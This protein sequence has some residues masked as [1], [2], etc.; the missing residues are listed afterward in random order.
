[1]L[2]EK[3]KESLKRRHD[4]AIVLKTKCNK[5]IAR[6]IMRDLD[7]QGFD[8]VLAECSGKQVRLTKE[9]ESDTIILEEPS[10]ARVIFVAY[11]DERA[12]LREAENLRFRKFKR[13]DDQTAYDKDKREKID[14]LDA[15]II[16]HEEKDFFKVA[17]KEKYEG[18]DF[19]TILTDGEI[20]LCVYKLVSSLQLT[21]STS[22]SYK[23][24]PVN[25]YPPLPNE[26]LI[27][28]LL[29]HGYITE[30]VPLHSRSRSKENYKPLFESV[31]KQYK[32]PVEDL[33]SYYG[34]SVAIYFEWCNFM[35]RWLLVPSIISIILWL[36]EFFNA[37]ARDNTL[38]NYMF[39]VGITIWSPMLVRFW[40]RRCSEIDIEWDNYNL[41]TSA[42]SFRQEFKGDIRINPVTDLEEDHY[43]SSQRLLRYIES[44]IIST[45]FMTLAFIV[46]ISS[47]N[48]MGYSDKDDLLAWEFFAQMARQGGIFEKGTLMANI[49]SLFMSITMITIGVFYESA[50][51]YA[52]VRENHKTKEAHINSVNIKKF[53]FNFLFYFGHL[54]YVA[55]QRRDIDGLKKELI[56]LALVDEARRIFSESA[57]PTFMKYGLHFD[58]KFGSA[59]EEELNELTLPEYTYFEDYLELVIQFGYVSMFAVAFPLGA[60]ITYVFLFFERRSDAYKIEKLCRRPL[61]LNTSDIGIWDEV[62]KLISFTSVFTNLFLF[63]FH[64]TADGVVSQGC[65]SSSYFIGIEHLL[66]IAIFILHAI[67]S[68]K[69]KWVSIFL[70]RVDHKE[71]KKLILTSALNKFKGAFAKIRGIK[72]LT[73]K[74]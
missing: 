39:A 65:E 44:F 20:N 55:F 6:A 48:M 71:K 10:N 21:K 67:I 8:T 73:K 37:D 12:I 52:T 59:I 69:P 30:M 7:E 53:T 43:P 17:E 72:F 25:V 15:R 5:E 62:M 13:P 36:G 64:K 58:K 40:R 14:Y 51:K 41:S 22:N 9:T 3:Y 1:M 70:Q 28:Y 31:M 57:L 26:A 34:E 27:F 60:F 74:D 63:S 42:V 4:L 16:K 19:N 18:G 45:P 49:P 11:D 38:F 50:A 23:A 35:A 54:F 66:I 33:R 32:A 2:K 24:L 29:K 47:L 46:M 61:S 56:V 68:T